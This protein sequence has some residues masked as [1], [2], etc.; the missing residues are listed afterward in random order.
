MHRIALACAFG[1][2]LVLAGTAAV[3][4]DGDLDPT[5]ANGGAAFADWATTASRDVRVAVDPS[6][7]VFVGATT[8]NPTNNRMFAVAKLRPDGSLHT[9]FGF[10]GLRTVDFDLVTNGWDQLRGVHPLAGDQLMLVGIAQ[11]P[12]NANA[13]AMARLTAAGNADT[14]FGAGGKRVITNSPWAIE[15]LEFEVTARQPDGKFVFAG[16][17]RDCPWSRGALVL[18]V[19]SNGT[20][21]PAFGTNGWASFAV[22]E[23]TTLEAVTIDPSGRIVLAGFDGDLAGDPHTPVLARFLPNGSADTSFGIGTGYV[24]LTNVPNPPPNGGWLGRTITADR[25]GSLLLALMMDE[26]MDST[27]A[28]IVRVRENGT[29]D[30]TFGIAGLRP[31]DLEG[32]VFINALTVRSDRRI[33]ATGSINHNGVSDVL[34][35]RLRSNGSLDPGFDGNGVARYSVDPQGGPAYAIT[36]DAGRPVIAGYARRDDSWDGF[37]LRLQ[38]DLIFADGVE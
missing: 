1:L 15:D 37:A 22:P 8:R 10:Q 28:G 29:L 7:N 21:D 3:A 38:S 24:R 35:A 27:R 2:G 30:T 16:W 18:R 34:V 14:A 17:C 23:R 32:G 20:P 13:P 31:L 33:I 12:G 25:D 36:L 11:I 5:F 26:D 9:G 4:D 19:D 6:G